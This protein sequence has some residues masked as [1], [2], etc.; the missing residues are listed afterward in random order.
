VEL[1]DL[2]NS[3]IDRL[4]N[5]QGLRI[6]G[7]KKGI[8]LERQLESKTFTDGFSKDDNAREGRDKSLE[9]FVSKGQEIQLKKISV[10]SG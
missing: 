4:I 8:E 6:I 7:I 9:Y 2:K 1:T 3:E 10:V 5:E